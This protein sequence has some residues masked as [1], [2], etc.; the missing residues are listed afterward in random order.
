MCG[1]AGVLGL[2]RDE[3]AARLRR[4]LGAI[5]H[6]GPDGEGV[7]L[8]DGVALGM[9]RLAIIDLA[10]GGQPIYDEE[11]A[12]AV[13]ANGEIYNYRELLA[14]LASRGHRFQSASDVNVI[15]HSYQERGVGAV[16]EWRGMFA[17]ALW[18][19]RRRKLVLWRDRVG[20]KPLYYAA[21]GNLFA[22]GSELGAVHALLGERRPL[23]RAAIGDYLRYGF[24]PQPATAFEGILSLPPGSVLEVEPGRAPVVRRYWRREAGA[25]FQGSRADALAELDRRLAEA[26]ELRLRS[27][28]PVGVFLSGGIDSGLVSHY[29]A[30][31]NRADLMAFVVGVAD[32]ALDESG[33]ATDV[34]RRLGIPV[35]RIDL[36]H[37][38][39]EVIERVAGLYGQPFADSSAVP[40]YLVSRQARAAR[41]VVLNGDGGDE[42]FGGYR[43][44]LLARRLR[45]AGRSVLS[46][47][48]AGLGQALAT[49]SRRRGGAGFLARALRGAAVGEEERYRVYTADVMTGG[50]LERCFPA[51][52]GETTLAPDERPRCRDL[53]SLMQSDFDHLLP[54]DLLVKMD[55]ATMAHGLEARSPML[56]APLVEFAWTLPDEW[57]VGWKTSKPLLRSLAA[58]RL[59][60][61]IGRAPKR[62]FEVPVARWLGGELRPMVQDLLL[63]SDGRVAEWGERGALAELVERRT[64]FAGNWAQSVWALLMLELFLRGET[65][66]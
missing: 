57:L 31:G 58:S 41:T 1:I 24:V 20:K 37:A 62:G 7:H 27:D 23:R 59:P 26:V 8:A 32:P 65:A 64:P 47:V 52:A 61:P 22:F 12:L 35:E 51:L 25:S 43:R 40:S 6:R 13:V 4:A 21:R 16:E 34:A 56:G 2:D 17:A 36:D 29:A 60:A 66:R 5:A 38:P 50:A 18:D 15:P 14:D 42:V 63:A 3:G 44:Y 30:K 10:G 33:P 54:S 46:P 48:A 19:D 49:R 39:T 53:R 28:V 9:R 55:I 45:G 11:R